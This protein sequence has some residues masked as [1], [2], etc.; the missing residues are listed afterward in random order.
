[1]YKRILS[2]VNEFTNSEVAAR[3]ALAL[4]AAC[5][6]ELLL[7]Y[8][9]EEL[10]TDE[11]IG[12]AERALE[13]LFRAARDRGIAVESITEQG[14]PLRKI[15]ATARRYGADIAF[16]ATRHEDVRQRFF[17]RTRAQQLMARLP[18]SAALVR[19]VRMGRVHPR[20][21]LAPL[22]GS[23]PHLEERAYF[24]AKLARG[25]E[26]PVTI[27]HLPAPLTDFFHGEFL[28]TAAEREQRLP[29]EVSRFIERVSHY[30]APPERRTGRGG[31]ARSITTEAALR[32]NDLIIMGASERGLLR[33]LLG[34]NPVEQV[35]RETPCNLIIFRPGRSGG[36][37]G[38]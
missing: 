13:R 2:A 14:D 16:I 12:R 27:F 18:C 10:A 36:R 7:A 28:Q 29:K 21:V 34:G 5:G 35:L 20:T 32:R 6:A 15:P 4:A 38:P 31:I 9:A 23:I 19:S 37:Q 17:S 33:S 11:A 22:K 30:G 24:T 1:M 8:S 25:L 26:A 3:Y